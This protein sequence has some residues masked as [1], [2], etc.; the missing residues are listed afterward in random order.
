M[1]DRGVEIR[2]A[3]RFRPGKEIGDDL[4]TAQRR[5]VSGV[6]NSR[7]PRV[8]TTWTEKSSC[9]KTAHEFRGFIRS[10]AA[11]YAECDAELVHGRSDFDK[12]KSFS[13]SY[14]LSVWRS[15]RDFPDYGLPGRGSA[16]V[17][18]KPRGL[19]NDR[20]YRSPIHIGC[21]GPDGVSCLRRVTCGACCRPCLR[22]S[23]RVR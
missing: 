22:R 5:K 7:A 4:L 19:G 21:P 8:I 23:N 12:R 2:V 15:T 9:C 17:S 13:N 18:S 1:L 20:G 10:Y 6:T 14:C 3:V 16:G 11:G